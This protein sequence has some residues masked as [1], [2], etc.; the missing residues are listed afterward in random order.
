MRRTLRRRELLAGFLGASF[1]LTWPL[2]SR[3]CGWDQDTVWVDA[4]YM[5]DI[6]A[7]MMGR[8]PRNPPLYYELR[9]E[10][11]KK[12]LAAR[13]TNLAAYDDAA[14]ASDRLGRPEEAI[15]LLDKKKLQLGAIPDSDVNKKEHL[16]RYLSNQGTVYYHRWL[17]SGAP[18]KDLAKDL[19]DVQKAKDLLAEAIRI[20]P[21]AHFGREKYQVLA[22]EWLLKPKKALLNIEIPNAETGEDEP[23]KLIPGFIKDVVKSDAALLKKYPDA[24]RG[25]AGLIALGASWESVDVFHN[26]A[27]V[28]RLVHGKIALSALASLRAAELVA[29]GKKSLHVN[30]AATASGIGFPMSSYR[31]EPRNWKEIQRL[32]GPITRQ[33]YKEMKGK[34]NLE[35]EYFLLRKEAEDWNSARTSYMMAQLQAGRH[36][37]TNADFWSEFKEPELPFLSRAQADPKQ[38]LL[39][40]FDGERAA[41]VVANK[42]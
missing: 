35:K 4:M 42:K 18:R 21:Q 17:K 37:D 5:R 26:L 23:F 39:L 29:Q 27:L 41:P 16:Y 14:V 38:N 40:D 33:Q 11:T 19:V 30:A 32:F 6:L 28:L 2:P 7:V 22:M 13:P 10:R 34:T 9:L 24:A 25:L 20:N 36:P 8:F 3:A 1:L 31:F 12:E 15:A